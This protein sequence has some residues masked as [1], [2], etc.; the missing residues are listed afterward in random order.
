MTYDPNTYGRGGRMKCDPADGTAPPLK[1]ES[2]KTHAVARILMWVVII[3]IVA[4]VVL[5][6]ATCGLLFI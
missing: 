6:F 3:F 4:P 2:E 1:T 5:S